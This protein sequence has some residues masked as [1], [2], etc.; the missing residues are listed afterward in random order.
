M[1]MLVYLIPAHV[2]WTLWMALG[3]MTAIEWVWEQAGWGERGARV[4]LALL[5]LAPLASL[6]WN[7]SSID[8]SWDSGAIDFARGALEELPER[9]ILISASD[10]HTF[11]LWYMQQVKGVFD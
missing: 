9:V 10:G 5:C 8:I 3:A 7:W 6:A 11:S 1:E 4:V 2:I